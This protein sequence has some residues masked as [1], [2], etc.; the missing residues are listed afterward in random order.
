MDKT[1]AVPGEKMTNSVDQ[2]LGCERKGKD[3]IGI[4]FFHFAIPIQYQENGQVVNLLP[5]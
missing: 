1:G 2:F 5:Q 3:D 4:H